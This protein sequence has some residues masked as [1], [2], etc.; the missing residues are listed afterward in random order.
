MVFLQHFPALQS[1]QKQYLL[2]FRVAIFLTWP[3]KMNAGE[4]RIVH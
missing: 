2:S 3:L 4:I 1:K